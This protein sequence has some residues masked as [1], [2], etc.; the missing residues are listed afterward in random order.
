MMD[1]VSTFLLL[2][3]PL[4]NTSSVC[5]SESRDVHTS[6]IPDAYAVHARI[7]EMRP[8]W[9]QV[10][11]DPRQDKTLRCAKASRMA[12]LATDPNPTF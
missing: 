4:G 1:R 3:P 10:G 11:V 7:V 9:R 2:G 12:C 6:S 5:L 8:I